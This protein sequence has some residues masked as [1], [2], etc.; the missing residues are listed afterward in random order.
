MTARS[1]PSRLGLGRL[2]YRIWY[3]PKG[4]IEQRNR[5][6]WINTWLSARGAAQMVRAVHSLP[7]LARPNETAPEIYFLSGK[8][9][10]HQTIFCA[11]S[12]AAFRSGGIRFVILDDGSLSSDERQAFETILQGCRIVGRDEIEARLDAHL[13][14]EKYPTLRAR[15]EVY[16]HLRKLVDVHAGLVGWKLVLDSDMLFHH[17]PDRLLAWIENPIAPIHMRDITSAYGYSDALLHELAGISVPQNVNV[18]VCGLSSGSIDWDLL[19]HWCRMLMTREGSHYLQEQALVA[20]MLAHGPR[21]ELPAS[22]GLVCPARQEVVAPT[23]AL[24]HYV[25]ESKAWY[26]R[27]AWRAVFAS[28]MARSTAS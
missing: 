16:P 6:G 22:E 26:F 8:R 21:V 20:L 12:L 28:A 15:R 10:S 19:E 24:H 18:G 17:R 5:H 13:P 11:Y 7:P 2:V 9:F 14:R 27:F 25:A 4:A 23:I 1:V 3:A